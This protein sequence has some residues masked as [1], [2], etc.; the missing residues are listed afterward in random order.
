MNE[1]RPARR[2]PSVDVVLRTAAG[3]VAAV[4]FGHDATVKA[5]RQ[6]VAAMRET[7]FA[8]QLAQL[9][10]RRGTLEGAHVPA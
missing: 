6:C 4:R 3:S 5:I 1:T 10:D 8:A 7:G 9:K 2:P